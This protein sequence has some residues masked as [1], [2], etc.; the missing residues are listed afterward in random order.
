MSGPC[1]ST[2]RGLYFDYTEPEKHPHDIVEIAHA[3]SRL[4]RYTGHVGDCYDPED[5]DLIYTVAQHSV[6]V[7]ELL[8]GTGQ[9]LAGLLH[10]ADEAFMNDMNSPL[11]SMLP[12]YKAI[13]HAVERP[14]LNHFGVPWP[15]DPRV[16]AADNFAMDCER[17]T[18]MRAAIRPHVRGWWPIDPAAKPLERVWG[19]GEAKRRFITR[20]YELRQR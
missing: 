13:E 16:K 12:E 3:L 8:E 20:F 7:S 15:L 6:L 14:L 17:L 5:D 2:S 10:D 19:I 11:K 4:C 1:I 9:E 18:F